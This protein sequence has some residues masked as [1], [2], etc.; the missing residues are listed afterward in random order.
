M[1]AIIEW[2]DALGH[3][4]GDKVTEESELDYTTEIIQRQLDPRF[5]IPGLARLMSQAELLTLIYTVTPYLDS[6]QTWVYLA[7]RGLP[8]L[9]VHVGTSM[10]VTAQ[11]YTQ[12][13]M[14]HT[15]SWYF[16]F[17]STVGEFYFTY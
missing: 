5:L 17:V 3:E 12:Q 2:I 10:W 1:P 6:Q 9:L 7:Q 16:D 14:K 4:E 8:T 15:V 13:N 11:P